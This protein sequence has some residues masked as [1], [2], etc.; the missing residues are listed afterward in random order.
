MK[1]TNI[2]VLFKG[3]GDVSGG[4]GA[5]RF[6]A[7]YFEDHRKS[8]SK[9]KLYFLTDDI[10]VKQY[11]KINK[12]NDKKQVLIFKNRN[13][14]LKDIIEFLSVMKFI[15]DNKIKLILIP[16]YNSFYFPLIR[17]IDQLPKFLRPKIVPV[18]VDYNLSYYYDDTNDQLYSFK[19]TY[20]NFFQ[21]IRINGVIT[22]Y[23]SFVQFAKER[24]L[25]KS[26]PKI[27]NVTVRY[28]KSIKP[29][30]YTEKKNHI[31]FAG[32]LT[33]TKQP[34]MFLKA[35]NLIK[36]ELLQ[37][38]WKVFVLG[39]GILE[40]KVKQFI[41]EN[42]LQALVVLTS[43]NDPKEFMRE[44]KCFVSTQNHENFPS[45]AMNEAMVTGNAIISRNVGQTDLFVKNNKN[46]FLLDKDDYFDLSRKI[47]QYVMLSQHQREAMSNYSIKLT[48]EVH[49]FQS[50]QYQ[51]E[52]IYSNILNNAD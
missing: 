32:R 11:K 52:T 12:L 17:R 4:G 31:V 7:D 26:N 1:S 44:S 19:N 20:E 35:I 40:E 15:I 34:L 9:Y 36:D 16:L 24:N 50:F 45:L 13:N 2:A 49:T 39:K 5:E 14:R 27:Y 33:E 8:D 42:K 48:N 29:L 51:M 41:E 23:A 38:G 47:L 30:A 25:I 43:H 21:N 18:I 3:I 28:T 22:W 6:F 46:G 37:S 10:S